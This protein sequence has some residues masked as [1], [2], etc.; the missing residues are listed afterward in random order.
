MH[1]A[2]QGWGG[3]RTS[4]KR[5]LDAT[6][7]S[8]RPTVTEGEGPRSENLPWRPATSSTGLACAP[9]C[10]YIYAAM[11]SFPCSVVHLPE[12]VEHCCM[13]HRHPRVVQR[14]SSAELF[15]QPRLVPPPCRTT[16]HPAAPPCTRGKFPCRR[17]RFAEDLPAYVSPRFQW[18]HADAR[19]NT[20]AL[21]W[22]CGGGLSS[23][24]G[25]LLC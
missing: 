9:R 17:C 18:F 4:C 20:T 13:W 7:P 19:R 24:T 12:W 10:S 11:T 25:Q 21:E 15:C 14:R 5:Y 8:R 2:S 1:A 23:N 22:S 16:R 3:R 6:Q